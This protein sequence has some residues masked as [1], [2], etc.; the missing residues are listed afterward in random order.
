MVQGDQKPGVLLVD[1]YNIIGK[2]H[3]G[4][5]RRHAADAG[6]NMPDPDF[7]SGAACLCSIDDDDQV[8]AP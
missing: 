8:G 1:G 2:L 6:F 5:L 3:E 7:R 4:A